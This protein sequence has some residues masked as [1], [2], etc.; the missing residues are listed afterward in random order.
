MTELVLQKGLRARSN[1]HNFV[2]AAKPH[3]FSPEATHKGCVGNGEQPKVFCLAHSSGPCWIILQPHHNQVLLS[4]L[5]M[6][7]IVI[8]MTFKALI[9]ENSPATSEIEALHGTRLNRLGLLIRPHTL[10]E[11]NPPHCN[12]IDLH[13]F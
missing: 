3:F 1:G 13:E 4:E 10:L 7:I 12:K 9:V 5:M 8:L 2:V 11:D 6:L